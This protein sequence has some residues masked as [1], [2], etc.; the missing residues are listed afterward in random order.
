V[1]D[2]HRAT[3]RRKDL[4]GGFDY[5][6]VGAGSAGCVVAGRLVEGTEATVLVLE[7]GGP[8]EGAASITNPPQWIE[9]IG[10]R[11]D[12]AYTY[13][14]SAQLDNRLLRLARGKVLGGSGSINAMLWARGNRTDYDGWAEAGNVGWDF[15]S[16]LPLFKKS[17]DW[18]GGANAFRG[19]GGPIRVERARDLDPVSTALIDA[20][21]SRGMPYLDDMNIPEP[22]GVGPQSLNVRDGR[23]CSPADAFLRPAMSSE[24]LTVL[25]GAQTVKLRLRGTR[26]IGVDVLIDGRLYSIDASREVILCAGAID[27]PRLL[28]LSGIGPQPE[29]KMLAIATVVD[30]PGVGRNLQDHVLVAGLCFEAKRRLPPPN[31]NLSGSVAFWKS[32]PE[33]GVPDLMLLPVQGPFLSDE[34]RARYPIPEDAF[35]ILLGLV[36]PRSRGFLR[37]KTSRHD[38]PLEIQ[39]NFLAEQADVDALVVGIELGLELASKPAFRDLIERRVAP[40]RGPSLSREEALMFLRRACTSYFHPVGTC[41]M[42]SGREAVVDAELRV[43]GVDGLRIADASIMPTITSANSNAPCVMIGEFAARRIVS[44]SSAKTTG[45]PG[46]EVDRH[47]GIR[48]SAP[49]FL[50]L[51]AARSSVPRPSALGPESGISLG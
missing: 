30:L 9:N 31:N 46:R 10:S 4:T 50:G 22:E 42:G 13:A 33:L 35:S 17:E 28:M 32:R 49:R 5:V 3:G 2:A 34:I 24:S 8:D 48:G 44:G 37:M 21:R 41:A 20:G 39:P 51:G 7:A 18:E 19:V 29:L 23:R 36:R 43:Y 47:R 14:P 38:G 45:P 11:Y 1:L 26:C 27:T 6:I 15:E 12:W 16:V 40:V 25:T